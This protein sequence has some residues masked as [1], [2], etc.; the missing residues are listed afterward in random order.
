M[1]DTAEE[2]AYE[3]CPPDPCEYCTGNSAVRDHEDGHLWTSWEWCQRMNAC[4]ATIDWE[5]IHAR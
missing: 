1:T 2:P 5:R 4:A 3:P